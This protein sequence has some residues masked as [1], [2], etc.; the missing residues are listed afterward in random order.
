MKDLLIFNWKAIDYKSGLKVAIGGI[1]LFGLS[2]TTQESWMATGL[3]LLF[4]WLTNVPGSLKDRITGMTAFAIGAIV[5]TIISGQIELSLWSNVA[6]IALIGFL[7]SILLIKGTR[8][9]MV[10]YVLICWAIYSPF[11][12]SS[13]SVNNCILAIVV[14]VGILI[15][16][17]FVASFFE[18]PTIQDET[19]DSS[20]VRV[21]TNYIIAYSVAIALVLGVTT[22][23][24][25]TSLKTDPTLVTGGAFFV[26]GF[27]AKKT[28]IIG[29][30]R[31]IGILTGMILGWILSSNLEPGL[32][33][34]SILLLALFLSF[35]MEPVHPGFLMFFFMVLISMGWQGLDNSEVNLNFYER[36]LGEGT[37]VLIAMVAIGFLQWLQS[38]QDHK[39]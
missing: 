4:A 6:G 19:T 21:D 26:I 16:L 32:L 35:A 15:L 11:L 28:K 7:G 36:L 39:S 31:V 33:Y 29:I 37:G 14:S 12:I 1:V 20:T 23:I 30:A 13:T 24:G 9:F 18:N 8:A 27:D 17:S 2:V 34:Y 10:G 22:Y 25:W 5:I 38:R 3:S